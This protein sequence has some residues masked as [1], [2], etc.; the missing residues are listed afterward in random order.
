MWAN[1][2]RDGCPAEYRW[3]PVLNAAKFG[4]C[5]LL[6]CCAV[7]LPTGERK[8]WRMQVNFAPSKILLRSNSRWKCV[9]SLPAQVRAKH[10]EKLGWLL[11]SDVA[12]VTKPKRENR[13]NYLGC[14]KLTNRSQLLVGR[15]SPHCEDMWR[16][17]CC[18]TSF[19]SWLLISALVVT[20]LCDGA[21]TAIFMVTLWNRADHYIF[22]L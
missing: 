9:Y 13:W 7:T 3:H 12:A 5:P 11:L 19:F 15:S 4:S 8:N 1:A 17:Y 6:D 16:R 2:Q 22:M 10:C 20:K 18:L 21:Q 14:P